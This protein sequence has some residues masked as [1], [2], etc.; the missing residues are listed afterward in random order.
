MGNEKLTIYGL[1]RDETLKLTEILIN[2]KKDY[3]VRFNEHEYGKT[4]MEEFSVDFYMKD[5][6]YL[7]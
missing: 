3:E 2:H 6:G 1:T 5:I 4:G 7:D